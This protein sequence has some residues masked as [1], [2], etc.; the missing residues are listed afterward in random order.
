MDRDII[1]IYNNKNIKFF[2]QDL[3]N[4]ILGVYSYIRKLKSHFLILNIEILG[5]KY[6]FLFVTFFNLYLVISIY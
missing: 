6:G 4:I 1:K 5:P 3:I 2:Y